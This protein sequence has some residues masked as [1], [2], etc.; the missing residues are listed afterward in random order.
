MYETILTEEIDAVGIVTL[1]RPDRLNAWTP[2]MGAE[3]RHAVQGFDSR[4]DI[5]VVVVTGA[6]RAFCAGA[7]ISDEAQS[8]RSGG[9]SLV[10]RE[11][12]YWQMNTPIIAAMNGTAVGVGM[13]V[14]MQWDFR[15][16]AEEA[17]YGFVFNR[18]GLL[19]ELGSTWI[20]PRLVGLAKSM[21]ILLT[22]RI[23]TGAEGAAMGLANVA[24]PASSVLDRSMELAHDIAANV[25][26]ASAALTKR[27]LNAFLV[28]SDR[29]QAE[30]LEK[31]LFMWTL[32]RD[33]AREGIQA[34][35]EKRPPQW[36]QSKHQLPD[37]LLRHLD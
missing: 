21:D 36:K 23:F 25:A 7:D 3:V 33:D 22:G 32:S 2:R 13:T 10:A 30:A 34:F 31:E 27:L 11:V 6:G 19:P 35:L 5:R 28:T 9:A 1:N 12:P 26:P 20:I 29:E 17:K 4:D 8:D 18:R 24:V 16:M 14:S 37:D 15:V